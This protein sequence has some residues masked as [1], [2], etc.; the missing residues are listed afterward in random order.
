M[1]QLAHDVGIL[2]FFS[3]AWFGLGLQLATIVKFCLLD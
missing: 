2:G 3:L 1:Q